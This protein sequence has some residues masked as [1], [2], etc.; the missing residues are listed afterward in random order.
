MRYS[1]FDS[2]GRWQASYS[3]NIPNISLKQ[4]KSWAIQTGKLVGGKVY[5]TIVPREKKY[6]AREHL[7]YDFTHLKSK[8]QE[9]SNYK[10]KVLKNKQ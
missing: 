10:K 6:E 8:L 5:E 3:H 7:L 1:V 9:P 2:H 4:V